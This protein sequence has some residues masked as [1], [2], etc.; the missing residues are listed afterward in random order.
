MNL[1]I[2]GIAITLAV[3]SAAPQSQTTPRAEF[4]VASIKP[5]PIARAGGEGSGRERVAVTPQSVTL[6][7]AGLSF[8]MQWAYDVKFY[9]V[10]G[11][12]RLVSERYDI[13]GKTDKPTGKEQLRTMMQ[14]LLADR[15]QLRFHRE[16]RTVPVYELVLVANTKLRPA[17]SGENPGLSVVNG[18]FVFR[19]LTMPEFAERLSD[20]S[21]IDRPVIDKT[22][23]E[24]LF[25]ITLESAA[26]AMRNDPDSIFPSL[27][28]AGLRLNSRKGPLEV[29]VVDQAR[30]PSEN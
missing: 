7:N 6:E 13:I 17:E 27:E 22:G 9:Q 26:S 21:A 18:S 10:K 3:G 16:T 4:D 20:L 15:F 19:R 1:K 28:R 29:L 14:A 8:C 12:D 24:G 5:S 23:R 11:P 2:I 30:K 25:D